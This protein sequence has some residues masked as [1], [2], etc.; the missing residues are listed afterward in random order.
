MAVL[1]F[2]LSLRPS[3]CLRTTVRHKEVFRNRSPCSKCSSRFE[4]RLVQGGLFDSSRKHKVV[5][6]HLTK[7]D[8]HKFPRSL[9]Q[10]TNHTQASGTGTIGRSRDWAGPGVDAP[11]MAFDSSCRASDAAPRD[12]WPNQSEP[13]SSDGPQ[14]VASRG[15]AA[16][17]QRRSYRV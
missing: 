7:P 14:I 4:K 12:H 3:R 1:P 10:K 6:P 11:L 9:R 8:T 17:I 15:E 16:R 5:L 2:F 13:E